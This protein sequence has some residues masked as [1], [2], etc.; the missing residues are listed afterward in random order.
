SVQASLILFNFQGPVRCSLIA[1][2]LFIISCSALFV[3]HF[4]QTFLKFVSGDSVFEVRRAA[5]SK[6]LAYYTNTPRNCQ[7]IFSGFFDFFRGSFY[8]RVSYLLYIEKQPPRRAAAA[9]C[10]LAGLDLIRFLVGAPSPA[11]GSWRG[12]A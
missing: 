10:L 11:G 6:Q 4:F 12:C 1:D 2:S 3:K 7:H 5:L 8:G 9:F